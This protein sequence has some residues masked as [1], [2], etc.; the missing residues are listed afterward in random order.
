MKKYTLLLLFGVLLSSYAETGDEVLEK[1]EETLLAPKDRIVVAKLVLVDKNNKKRIRKIKMWQKGKEKR[2][3]KFLEPADVKGVG[4]LVPSENELYLWMPAFS[5]IRRIASHVKH[6][7]FMGTDFSYEDIGETGYK[8]KYKAKVEKE[9]KKYYVLRLTPKKKDVYYGMLRMWVSKE[10]YLPIKVEF[11]SKKKKLLKVM[12]AQKIEKIDGFWT[13]V[14]IE[15]R[16]IQTG[17][18]TIMELCEINYNTGIKNKL[19]TKSYLKRAR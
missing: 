11:Y 3:V 4:L 13:H 7:S 17:H 19:F 2:L 9:E 10:S 14:K 8:G 5:K 16:N 12:E 18:K 1:V 15:M 6:Q